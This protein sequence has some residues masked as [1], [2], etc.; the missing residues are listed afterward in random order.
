VIPS[1][2]TRP[3]ETPTVFLGGT[4]GGDQWRDRFMSQLDDMEIS[5]FNPQVA[6]WNPWMLEMEN[7][8]IRNS[9]VLLFPVLET[10]LGL[11]SL[12]ELG[13]SVLSI[14]RDIQSGKN[15]EIIILIDR[16]CS[17]EITLEVENAG[18]I[19]E[20]VPVSPGLV[21][22]SNRMRSLVRSKVEAETWRQGV[23]LVE[24]LDDMSATLA[25]LL[26]CGHLYSPG[27]TV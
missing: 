3:N 21:A 6:D 17:P 10:T 25:R 16:Y 20:Q 14:L 9:P 22:E 13:F 27:A 2:A 8:C 23:H 18:G 12:G 15:R 7:H 19:V 5:Y 1:I 26:R 24:N 11:G 4:C